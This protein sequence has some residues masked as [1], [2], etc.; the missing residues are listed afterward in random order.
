MARLVLKFGGTSVADIARIRKVARLVKLQLDLGHEIAV[1]LSAMAGETNK[2]VALAREMQKVP[3]PREYDLIISAGEQVTVGLLAMA[4]EDIGASA[5]SFLGWQI[6]IRTSDQ[7]GNAWI[8]QV[9]GQKL[10]ALMQQKIIPVIAGFQGVSPDGSVTTLGRGGSDTTAVAVAAAVKADQCDIYTDVEGVFT[11]DPRIVDN[12]RKLEKISYEEMQEFAS[13][14]AKVLQPQSVEVARRN[15]VRVQVLSSF[16]NE[17]GTFMVDE[18]EISNIR[19]VSGL[20]YSKEDTKIEIN[21][22]VQ[23]KE[24][25]ALLDAANIPVDMVAKNTSLVFTVPKVD[26]DRAVKM[27]RQSQS[28]LGFSDIMAD[29]N[30]AKVSIV[31]LGIRN[32]PSAAETMLDTLT[33]KSIAIYATTKCDIKVTVLIG[34]EHLE[35]A[36]R[37]LHVAFALDQ[38]EKTKSVAA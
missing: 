12:A 3:N 16:K 4:L 1:V 5:R 25:F 8:D 14:G 18:K 32:H 35:S 37:A 24:I 9:E 15:K 6:P 2:L 17:A 31:G 21:G 7:Y 30:I 38:D 22:A 27:L 29:V 33:E 11:T 23:D 26:L 28:K 36:L 19:S 34:A 13:Q 20:A 10:I